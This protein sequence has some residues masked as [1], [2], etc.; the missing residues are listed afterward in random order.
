MEFFSKLFSSKPSSKEVAKDRLKLILIH[1]RGDLSP[2]L[3]DMIK[4]EILEVITKYVE[5][6][7]SDV[8][9]ALTRTSES[10]GNSP[11]LIANIPIKKLKQR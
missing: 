7:S 3:L 4:S 8:E 11:A 9:I 1:D 2:Q 5:I 6:D 10:E